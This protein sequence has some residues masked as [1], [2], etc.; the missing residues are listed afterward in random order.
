MD[1]IIEGDMR[2]ILAG[3]DPDDAGEVDLVLTDPPYN[4]GFGGYDSHNDNMPDEEYIE[5]LA[6]LQRFRR[7]VVIHYPEEMMRLVLPALGNPDH[8]GTWCY[9]SNLPRRFR[10][11]AYFGL[12]PDYTRLQQPYKNPSDARVRQ[13]IAEGHKGS[14][15]YE[16]WDDIQL[17]KNVSSEKTEH[18]CPVPVRL[19]ERIILLTTN[20]GDVVLDPF[21]GSGTTAV[22][23]KRNGRRFVGIEVSA[24]YALL[25]RQRLDG[26][27]TP[28]LVLERGA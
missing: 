13:L 18:P 5:M 2:S 11:I 20:P 17:V 6:E 26:T 28:L 7:V 1:E 22:A 25:A 8:V 4:I 14:A 9:S 3:M 24:H 10:L 23:A 19:M 15:L 16:W 12:T 27:P 21:V